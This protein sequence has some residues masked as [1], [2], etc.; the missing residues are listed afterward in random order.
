MRLG[1]GTSGLR[2][3]P[4]RAGK[5]RRSSG[6]RVG[7]GA[8]GE[9]GIG[10]CQRESCDWAGGRGRDGR[11]ARDRARRKTEDLGLPR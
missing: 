9:K 7:Q 1:S 11:C 3:S 2:N 4:T 5:E 6:R 10:V 8:L